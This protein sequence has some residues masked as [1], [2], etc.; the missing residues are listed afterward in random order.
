[1]IARKAGVQPKEILNCYTEE[2]FV[3]YINRKVKRKI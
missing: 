1:M 3:K 2:E